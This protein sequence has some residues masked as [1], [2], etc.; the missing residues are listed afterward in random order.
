M[1]GSSERSISLTIGSSAS[2]GS[3][4]FAM[5]TLSRTFWNAS[6]SEIW[7]GMNSTTI[8]ETPSVEVERISS[9]PAM[10]CSSSSM[11]LVISDSMSSG[12]A[13]G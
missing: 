2:S 13:P 1:M 6:S 9:I 11:G 4:A 12:L 10:P 3:S 8:V 7:S 5:S